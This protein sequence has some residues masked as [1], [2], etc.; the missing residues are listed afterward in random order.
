MEG[1]IYRTVDPKFPVLIGD[2]KETQFP[3]LPIGML[4]LWR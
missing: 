1:F 2:K 3:K 4:D